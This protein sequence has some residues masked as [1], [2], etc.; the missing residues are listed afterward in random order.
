MPK[1]QTMPMAESSWIFPFRAPHSIPSDD[2]T[3]NT[4]APRMGFRPK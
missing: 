4:S 3:A 1:L 2:I